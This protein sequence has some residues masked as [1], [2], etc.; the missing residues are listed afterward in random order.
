M[1][2]DLNNYEITIKEQLLQIKTNE[3]KSL[4][5]APPKIITKEVVNTCLYKSI[6]YS[7]S[8]YKISKVCYIN[9]FELEFPRS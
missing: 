2:I 6:F 4:V 5:M 9:K 7:M 1:Y 8:H 3:W